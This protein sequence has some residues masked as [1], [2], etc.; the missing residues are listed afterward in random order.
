VAAHVLARHR[1]VGGVL[2]AR[3][4][5]VVEA[6]QVAQR[7][8]DEL[9]DVLGEHPQHADQVLR[10]PVADHPR[11]A[12]AD[13]AEPPEPGEERLGP[14]EADR[15]CGAG[16]GALG[17]RAALDRAVR[18]HQPQGHALRGGADQAP[19]DR[20]PQAVLPRV[21]QSRPDAVR[22]TGDDTLLGGAGAR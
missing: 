10:V 13:E 7:P 12:E 5:P 3:L 1:R 22:G 4:P 16:S 21:L 18:P 9:L 17:G 6:P 15:G 19:G 11:L 8:R 14:D 2:L 20:H